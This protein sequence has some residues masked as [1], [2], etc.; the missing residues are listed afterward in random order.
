MNKNVVNDKGGTKVAGDFT[1]KV[2][3]GTAVGFTQ[4]GQAPLKG[5]NTLDCRR[6]HV[7]GRRSLQWRATT[8]SFGGTAPAS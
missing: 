2:N 5:A 6:R 3:G 8:A 1:F 7:H 4:D